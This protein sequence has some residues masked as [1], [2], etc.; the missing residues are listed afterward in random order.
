MHLYIVYI[1]IYMHII[2]KYMC[3][4][5]REWYIYFLSFFSYIF[6]FLHFY[7]SQFS[8][9]IFFFFLFAFNTSS[10]TPCIPPFPSPPATKCHPLKKKY[11]GANLSS[12]S[13]QFNPIFRQIGGDS[14]Y[15]DDVYPTIALPLS[16][17]A[18][19]YSVYMYIYI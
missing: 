1:Y 14:F 10:L 5:V 7:R 15:L 19:I 9:R 13:K 6:T 18:F 3:K 17:M 11:T 4:C 2:Y 16:S 12:F 8:Y